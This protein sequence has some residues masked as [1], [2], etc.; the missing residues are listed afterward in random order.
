MLKD[1][2]SAITE[3][4]KDA[5]DFAAKIKA[6]AAALSGNVWDILKVVVND[7]VMCSTNVPRSLPIVRQ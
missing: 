6:V 3:C 1:F 2:G 7:A 4:V 5:K